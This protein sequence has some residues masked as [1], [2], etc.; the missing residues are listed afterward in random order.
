MSLRSPRVNVVANGSPVPGIID[1]DVISNNHFAADR[2]SATIALGA[3]AWSSASFWSSQA[4]IQ[5]DIQI[6][7]DGI[8][9]TSMVQGAVDVV[10][11]DFVGGTMRWDGR[12]LTATLIEARTQETFANHTSSE[13]AIL[14]AQ[15]HNLTP[16]VT[17]TTAPVGRYYQDEH[18]RV[19][20]DQFSRSTTEWDLLVFL[21]NQ[22]GFDIFV[23]G[24]TLYFQAP[25]QPSAA[26]GIL[27]PTDLMGLKLDRALTLARDIEVTVKSWNSRQQAAFTQTARATRQPGS[28]QG[29]PPQRYVYVRPNLTSADALKFAQAKLAELT[30][31]ERVIEFEMAG[32]LQMTPRSVVT[33]DDTGTEF[34]QSYCVDTIERHL[35]LRDGFTQRVRARNMSPSAATTPPSD[36]VAS[37]S[38]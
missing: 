32:E 12:D 33:L 22:E 6:S 34:D 26:S 35:R 1:V 38:G 31:H 9:F 18:D 29:G 30:R 16:C 10:A 7:L 20:L 4:D 3:A 36:I 24:T 14:L 15:R 13:I 17:Q 5:L 27:N 28:R 21:A 19:T 8:S 11:I 25:T 23:Q 2:F 37:I